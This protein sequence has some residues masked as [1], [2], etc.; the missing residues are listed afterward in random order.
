VQIF[1]DMKLDGSTREYTE[2]EVASR[3]TKEKID[4]ERELKC[5]V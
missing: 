5:G 1:G 4:P 2:L 3:L